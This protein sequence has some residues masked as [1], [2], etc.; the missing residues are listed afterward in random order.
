MVV[1]VSHAPASTDIATLRMK[2]ALLGN[3]FLHHITLYEVS[4]TIRFRWL[5]VL[6]HITFIRVRTKKYTNEWEGD[7]FWIP[8]LTSLFLV[9]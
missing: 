6:V 3:L 1:D 9:Y 4:R 7:R 5:I 2:H 8:N